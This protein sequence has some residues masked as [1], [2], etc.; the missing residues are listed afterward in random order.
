[1]ISPHTPVLSVS[2]T[3]EK[4]IKE[5]NL[6]EQCSNSG[7]MTNQLIVGKNEKEATFLSRVIP[8]PLPRALHY[9]GLFTVI[10]AFHFYSI[11]SAIPSSV[12][13]LT[14][15]NSKA[16]GSGINSAPQQNSSICSGEPTEANVLVF[17]I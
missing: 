17:G 9:P 15:L 4:I 2:F 7:L 10:C 12:C 3:I 1:M 14:N 8:S 5:V 11:P 13:L 6:G 16:T